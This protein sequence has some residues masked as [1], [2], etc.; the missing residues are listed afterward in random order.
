MAAEPDTLTHMVRL[1]ERWF[2][3]NHAFSVAAAGRHQVPFATMSAAMGG[4][5]RVGL[6]DNLYIERGRLARPN[7]EQVAR[8]REIVE[9]MGRRVATP[10][11]VRG[12]LALKG[13]RQ[14]RASAWA[15]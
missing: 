11:E 14:A 5:V 4:H 1:A 15:R 6:E 7:A 2:G 3:A 13:A 8:I 9:R 10:D 12:M